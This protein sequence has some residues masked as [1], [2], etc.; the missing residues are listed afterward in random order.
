M[1]EHSAHDEGRCSNLTANK[2][3]QLDR[4]LF[5]EN[6]EVKMLQI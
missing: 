4:S 5:E 1:R 2:E 3:P 6:G